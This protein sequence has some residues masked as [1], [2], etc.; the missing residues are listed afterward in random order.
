MDR[1][2]V[3]DECIRRSL[4]ADGSLASGIGTI[5]ALSDG[6]RAGRQSSEF[7]A[8]G[9]AV[10]RASSGRPPGHVHVTTCE[11]VLDGF[12]LHSGTSTPKCAP[13]LH[14]RRHRAV[15]S[16]HCMPSQM[17]STPHFKCGVPP[18]GQFRLSKVAG[19]GCRALTREHAT[20]G[21]F[22]S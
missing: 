2:P 12:S 18:R 14:K 19:Q 3:T 22:A 8:L 1:K 4:Q 5:V 13:D 9:D 16:W 20:P 15:H 11:C 17:W 6:R 10:G 21:F 7:R